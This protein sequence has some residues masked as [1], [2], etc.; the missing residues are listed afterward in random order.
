MR[1]LVINGELNKTIMEAYL[2]MKRTGEVILYEIGNG[3]KVLLLPSYKDQKAKENEAGKAKVLLLKYNLK[4]QKIPFLT[5][6][7]I[8]KNLLTKTKIR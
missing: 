8:F 6:D 2:Q 3:E 4:T 1:E 7:P 5:E